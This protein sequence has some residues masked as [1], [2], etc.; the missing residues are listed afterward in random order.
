MALVRQSLGASDI[1][2][3]ER[4]EERFIETLHL[5]EPVWDLRILMHYLGELM[6]RLAERLTLRGLYAAA[7][8]RARL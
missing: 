5:D 8:R 4:E 1:L 6:D 3:S 2:R 7:H